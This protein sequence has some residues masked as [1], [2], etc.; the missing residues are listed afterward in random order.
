M[1]FTNREI[2]G[3]E[4]NKICEDFRKIEIEHGIS[5]ANTKRINITVEEDCNIVGFASGL[6][7][8]EWCNLTDL[9]I[10]E[11]YRGQGL[12]AKILKMFEEKAK[13]EKIKHIYT[14]TTAYNF[15]EKF[16]EKQGYKQCLVFEDF[17]GK[18][19][20][21]HICLRKDITD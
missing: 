16:Y 15:N 8:H 17:F 4:Y 10:C 9:W 6:T 5:E 1:E 18:K 20:S 21:H 12:G 13:S 2:T 7:N 3:D 14:W 19:G 11:K